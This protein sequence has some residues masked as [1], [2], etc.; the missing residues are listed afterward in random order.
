MSQ[1]SARTLFPYLITLTPDP[2]DRFAFLQNCI[3]SHIN[4]DSQL[5]E[6]FIFVCYVKWKNCCPAYTRLQTELC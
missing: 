6:R 2:G 1:I 5:I 3:Q 4:M